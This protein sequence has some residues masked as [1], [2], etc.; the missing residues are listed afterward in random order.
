MACVLCFAAGR[1][2]AED[3]I[4]AITVDGSSVPVAGTVTVNVDVEAE[5]YFS[6][7]D[8]EVEFGLAT[9]LDILGI[10]DIEAATQYGVN[11]TTLV[12]VSNDEAGVYG[13]DGWRDYQGDFA[14]YGTSDGMVCVKIN[15]PSSGLID[16]IG[17]I[18]TSWEE[19]DTYTALWGFVAGGKAAIVKVV[20]N[21]TAN[22]SVPAPEAE[23]DITKL[24]IVGKA[25]CTTER[26]SYNGF[27]T[28]DCEVSVSGISSLLGVEAE[29]LEEWVDNEAVVYVAFN[30]DLGIKVDSLQLLDYTDGWLQRT[31]EDWGDMAGDELNECCATAYNGNS[32]YFIQSTWYDPSDDTF[33]FVV[34]QYPG[35]LAV[36]DSLYAD[37]YIVNGTKAYVIRHNMIIIEAADAGGPDDM[38][39]VGGET[40]EVEEYVDNSFSYSL[41]Y[42]N[43]DEA[44]T[45]LGCDAS[46]LALN[47]L[48]SASSFY[49]GSGTANN[50]GCWLTSDG[51]V[52]SYGSNPVF[53][54]PETSGDY[55]VLHIGQMPYLCS[56][57]DEYTIPLYLTYG[58]SYYLVTVHLTII[59]KEAIDYDNLESMATFNLTITQEYDDTYEYPFS[60]EAG[61]DM[62]TIEDK[63]GTDSPTL[64]GTLSPEDAEDNGGVAYTEDYTCTPYPGFWLTTEGYVTTWGTDSYWGACMEIGENDEGV[65]Q[66]LFSCC[67][68]P[69]FASDGDSYKT[70]LYLINRETGKMVTV[71][72]TYQIGEVTEY[73]NVGSCSIIVPVSE[74][75][76]GVD[77]DLSEIAEAL[78]T[79]MD[80]LEQSYCLCAKNGYTTT[81][82]LSG[83]LEF[84]LDGLCVAP[85]EGA[86]MVYF[87]GGQIVT[88]GSDLAEDKTI[89]TDIYIQI[90][91]S[92]YT[93][94]ITFMN[95][96]DYAGVSAVAADKASSSAV[97]DL[98]GRQVSKA[99]KGIYV[100]G[101]KKYINK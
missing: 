81:S 25:E 30:N 95:A 51:Y 33:G 43:L 76:T 24:E 96:D 97:Y 21:F 61:I 4:T 78:G 100:T 37:L 34:G 72:L 58:D 14:T 39:K 36:G 66:A 67:H 53:I 42:P 75:E 70:T 23:L 59:A 48:S 50:G 55:S 15:D 5:T 7:G 89:Q 16:Y 52:G 20:I 98:S 80:E 6:P 17:C 56:E 10:S 12:A 87:E 8:V 47:F 93:I 1:A 83:G 45:L 101:G 57:G 29:D 3:E 68:H 99:Q 69:D 92:R 2:M 90:G 32:S 22:T 54:E 26:Y 84:D 82:T 9:V 85:G 13:Y 60:D 88:Y 64:F 63:I 62:S 40:I 77:F 18:D 49:V 28:T 65:S 71:N 38:T 41:I 31:C 94:T 44:A 73:E 91:S 46:N 19:G 11:V 79:D 74:D 27:D 35:N 86:I